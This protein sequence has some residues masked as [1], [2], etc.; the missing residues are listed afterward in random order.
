[1]RQWFQE[2]ETVV[3]PQK[4]CVLVVGDGSREVHGANLPEI[5]SQ[6]A[7]NEVEGYDHNRIVFFL[8]SFSISISSIG[9]PWL[10]SSVKTK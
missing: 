4:Y 5:I 10:S 3:K 8:L 9:G 6:I 7:T 1:M 2:V